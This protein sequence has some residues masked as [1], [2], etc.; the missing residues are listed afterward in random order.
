MGL[1]L[2]DRLLKSKSNNNK[3]SSARIAKVRRK[4]MKQ[5]KND[6]VQ[7]CISILNTI[8][9]MGISILAGILLT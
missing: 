9:A 3:K 1:I 2:V 4:V 6:F 5:T 8:W 7:W